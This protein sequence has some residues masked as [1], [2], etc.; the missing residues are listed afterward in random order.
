MKAQVLYEIG[1]IKYTDVKKP[2]IKEDEALI[3]VSAC[4]ICGSDIP[5]IY[6]TGAHNMPLIPGHEMSGVVEKC[7]MKPELVGRRVGIFP[8]IPCQKCAQCQNG[9]YEMCENYNYLGSRCDGGFAEYVSVPVWN[10]IPVPDCITEEEAAMLEPMCV[11]V[12]AMKMIGLKDSSGTRD[13]C[14]IAV[15]GLGTIGLFVAMFLKDAG[16]QNVYCI[17]NKDIQKAK[18]LE[19]GYQEGSFCDVRNTDPYEFI[20][21]KT[22]GAGADY[23]FECIGRSDNYEQAVKC[24]SPLGKIMLVGNPASDMNLSRDI[25]WKILRNQLTLKGTWNSSYPDDW[26]YAI[27]RLTSWHSIKE[28]SEGKS[29]DSF[30]MD[31]STFITHRFPLENIDKGLSIMRNK[32]EEYIKVMITV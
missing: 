12:H 30:A 9:H 24:V 5:R 22:D 18:L 32:S 25:Y 23:Y 26:T 3:T 11:A 13:T 14:T 29:K 4:G 8:L 19:M 17:G 2:D 15:C 6:K 21:D 16:Y 7:P 28:G 31:P 1:N 20:K 10:L 27:E